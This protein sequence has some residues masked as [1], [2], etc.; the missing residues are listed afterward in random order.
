MSLG[1]LMNKMRLIPPLLE[2]HENEMKSR[3]EKHVELRRHS[4][5][6][7]GFVCLLVCL[8]PVR[9]RDFKNT[10]VGGDEVCGSQEKRQVGMES[11]RKLKS[12][13]HR[14]GAHAFLKHE[15]EGR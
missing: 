15:R 11:G 7:S 14:D 12:P 4:V 8:F 13:P 6:G 3:C 2:F 9:K 10:R 5:S 1:F